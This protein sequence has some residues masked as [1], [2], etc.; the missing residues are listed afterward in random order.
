[1]RGLG[2]LINTRPLRREE[3]RMGME[4]NGE[5]LKDGTGGFDVDIFS[6]P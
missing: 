1:M 3:E 5:S 6:D 4:A 2:V